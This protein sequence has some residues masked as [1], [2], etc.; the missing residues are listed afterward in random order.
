MSSFASLARAIQRPDRRLYANLPTGNLAVIL[1]IDYAIVAKC[2]TGQ[3]LRLFLAC[4]NK[5]GLK[6]APLIWILLE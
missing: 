6:G 4:D 2:E 3:K 1:L 5:T